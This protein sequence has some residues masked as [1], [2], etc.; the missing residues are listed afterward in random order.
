M[1]RS[2]QDGGLLEL[3]V[4]R[5]EIGER[6]LLDEA[7]LD[8][9]VGLV[10]DNWLARGSR[11]TDD[12]TAV[13]GAQIALMNSRIAQLVAQDQSRWPLAGDQLYVDLDLSSDNLPPGQR[14]RLGTALLEV[15][16]EPHT[17]CKKFSARFGVDA[18]AFISTPEGK[19]QRL[20][21]MYVVVIEA[22]R[23]RVG[24][25]LAKV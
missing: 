25:R 18:L 16:P 2:P 14:L 17:G 5:P 3:I 1:E 7:E 4:A 19:A 20:R 22:G 8:S 21:G 12:G 24:D 9:R 11:H 23:I 15:T 13:P 10:G 6:L